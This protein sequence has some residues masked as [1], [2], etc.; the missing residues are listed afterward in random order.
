MPKALIASVGGTQE[1][2][3]R[4]LAHHKPDF[5]CFLV[6]ARSEGQVARIKQNLA[7]NGVAFADQQV[8]LHD[9]EDLAACYDDALRCFDKAA[10]QGYFPPMSWW[11]TPA[12]PR[13]CPPPL[14]WRASPEVAPSRMSAEN[15]TRMD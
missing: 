10:E 13:A 14:P 7:A 15:G 1:P 3:E 4:S 8:V 2:I 5:V 12:A 11:I 9:P 6:S